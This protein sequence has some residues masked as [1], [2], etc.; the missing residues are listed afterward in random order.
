MRFGSLD[1][2]GV[3]LTVVPSSANKEGILAIIKGRVC[4]KSLPRPLT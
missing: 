2:N 3:I 4:R 1:L